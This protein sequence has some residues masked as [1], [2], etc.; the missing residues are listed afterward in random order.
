M[1][2]SIKKRKSIPALRVYTKNDKIY[3][4]QENEK[5]YYIPLRWIH[6]EGFNQ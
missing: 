5:P 4:N 3:M 2:S 6:I 1:K